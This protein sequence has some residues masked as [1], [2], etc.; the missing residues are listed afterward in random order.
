MYIIKILLHQT[1]NDINLKTKHD[2]YCFKCH[3]AGEVVACTSCTRVYHVRCL[4]KE[5]GNWDTFVCKACEVGIKTYSYKYTDTNSGLQDCKTLNE[6]P[7]LERAELNQILSFVVAHLE[8]DVK[9]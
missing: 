7:E 9:I 6:T 5:E 4:E 1:P 8:H 2:W 3:K